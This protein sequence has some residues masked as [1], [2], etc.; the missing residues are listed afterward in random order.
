MI[1]KMKMTDVFL[2]IF[3]FQFYNKSLTLSRRKSGTV[4]EYNNKKIQIYHQVFQI[5]STASQQ[6][7]GWKSVVC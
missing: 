4:T 1:H 5:I 3:M 7:M 2:P 6:N